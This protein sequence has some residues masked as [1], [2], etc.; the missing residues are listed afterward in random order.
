MSCKFQQFQIPWHDVQHVNLWGLDRVGT[1]CSRICEHHDLQE[2]HCCRLQSTGQHW[3]RL[4]VPLSASQTGRTQTWWRDRH[5]TGLNHRPYIDGPHADWVNIS[6]SKELQ[7]TSV[8]Q[9]AGNTPMYP[10]LG[11][12]HPVVCLN[13]H[14][15]SHLQWPP[16]HGNRR[17][18]VFLH[19]LHHQSRV[20][21]HHQ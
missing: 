1:G 8:K 13:G 2:W 7:A 10:V 17:L 14:S 19:R 11:L 4:N 20:H 5:V 21:L 3:Y 9:S 16:P 18:D 12:H 15:D 6:H